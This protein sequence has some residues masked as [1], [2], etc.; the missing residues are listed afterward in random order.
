MKQK[1]EDLAQ[2]ILISG[3]LF[4]MCFMI[5]KAFSDNVPEK[6]HIMKVENGEIKHYYIR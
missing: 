4:T 3:L 6:R 1:R 5:S 2:W